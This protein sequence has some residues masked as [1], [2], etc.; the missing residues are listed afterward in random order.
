MDVTLFLK[1]AIEILIQFFVK[2]GNLSLIF[3]TVSGYRILVLRVNDVK[4]IYSKA[5]SPEER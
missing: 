2:D 5:K 4:T 3:A 1:R